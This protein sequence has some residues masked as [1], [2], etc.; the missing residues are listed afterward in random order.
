MR[1]IPL[2]CSPA[3]HCRQAANFHT[4]LLRVG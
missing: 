4:D 1:G 3:A 2:C